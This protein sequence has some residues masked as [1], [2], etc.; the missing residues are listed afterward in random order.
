MGLDIALM[1]HIKGQYRALENHKFLWC[2]GNQAE[3]EHR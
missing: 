3:L 1:L 2:R